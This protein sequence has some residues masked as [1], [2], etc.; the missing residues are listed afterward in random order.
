VRVRKVCSKARSKSIDK[1]LAIGIVTIEST[2]LQPQRIHRFDRPR[3]VG[4]FTG[5]LE[6][7]RF[8]WGSDRECIERLARSGNKRMKALVIYLMTPRTTF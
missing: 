4:Q 8:E 6:C 3:R 1:S 7:E 2:I 5:A